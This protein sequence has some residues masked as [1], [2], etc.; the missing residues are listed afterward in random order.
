MT[1][2]AKDIREDVLPGPGL[3]GDLIASTDAYPSAGP[4][5]GSG[6]QTLAPGVIAP[7]RPGAILL[8]RHGEPALSRRVKLDAEGYRRWWSLYEEGG[9][10]PGQTP[11]EPLRQIAGTAQVVC[12]TRRRSV[13]TA[14]AVCG[15]GPFASSALFIEAPLP[16]PRLPSFL[17]FRPRAW[18]VISRISWWLGNHQGEEGRPAAQV[19]A[20]RA[21]DQLADM[22]DGGQDVLLL[23]HGYFNAMVGFELKRLGWR[24]VDDPGYAYWSARRFE[25]S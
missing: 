3:K 13:E 4:K 19:R 21:A 16:P 22:A 6:S 23:A 9:L 12:S 2:Q 24:L 18:G 14:K 20:R 1:G 17:R 5:A 15:A 8:A 25:K 7:A 10:L 11:P